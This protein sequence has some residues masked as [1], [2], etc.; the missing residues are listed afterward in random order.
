MKFKIIYISI[1]IILF[2]SCQTNKSKEKHKG[3]K[4]TVAARQEKTAVESD[5]FE[6]KANKFLL[7]TYKFK[8]YHNARF[9]YC[10]NYPSSILLPQGES[11]NGD[12]QVFLSN[13]MKFS[14]VVS[15]I[16]NSENIDIRTAYE[17]DL[18][19]QSS[20]PKNRLTLCKQVQNYYVISGY[21]GDDIFYSKTYLFQNKFYSIYFEYP[22]VDHTVTDN[23]IKE[24]L[25]TFPFCK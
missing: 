7:E 25:K 18:N 15:G 22:Q 4:D 20:I 5:E 13:D 17:K 3:T 23:L 1:I 9:N 10:I 19:Y 2:S 11:E 12:G 14:M 6:P 8:V 16:S 24:T 21:K